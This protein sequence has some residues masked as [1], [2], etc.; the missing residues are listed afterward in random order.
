[1]AESVKSNEKITNLLKSL[2]ETN[3]RNASIAEICGEIITRLLKNFRNL[4][5]IYDNISDII[6]II[7]SLILSYIILVIL[8]LFL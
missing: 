3:E 2:K 5:S 8:H 6:I 1:M 7:I 4:R